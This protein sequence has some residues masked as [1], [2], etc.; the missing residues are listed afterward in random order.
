MTLIE[1]SRPMYDAFFIKPSQTWAAY[2]VNENRDQIGP[3]GYGESKDMAVKEAEDAY[4]LERIKER[5]R[6]GL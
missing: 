4:R 5:E 3:L 6:S 2:R 1:Y